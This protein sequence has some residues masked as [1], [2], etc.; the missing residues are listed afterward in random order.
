MDDRRNLGVVDRRGITRGTKSWILMGNL[1]LVGAAVLLEV[2]VES[3]C[4]GVVLRRNEKV[5]SPTSTG[6][7]TGGAW[8]GGRT[9]P[10]TFAGFNLLAS[11]WPDSA[12][13]DPQT[14]P[15]TRVG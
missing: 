3:G 8:R 4:D 11:V 12:G 14:D 6:C 2:L 5:V 1:A 15:A 7:P 9:R 13:C 10:R